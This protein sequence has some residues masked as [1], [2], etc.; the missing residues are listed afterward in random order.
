MGK[1]NL[2]KAKEL[3]SSRA[4]SRTTVSSFHTVRH[5]EHPGILPKMV[6]TNLERINSLILS[7]RYVLEQDIIS[8]SGKKRYKIYTSS[9]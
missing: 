2:P 1:S 9:P 8:W 6:K 5:E 3:G 7:M 4:G